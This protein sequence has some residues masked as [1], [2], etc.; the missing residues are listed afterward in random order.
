MLVSFSIIELYRDITVL[1]HFK[2][3]ISK[4]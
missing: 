4:P 1:V 2:N 3:C